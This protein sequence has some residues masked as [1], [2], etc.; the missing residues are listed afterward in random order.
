MSAGSAIEKLLDKIDSDLSDFLVFAGILDNNAKLLSYRV[1]KSSFSL[2]IERHDTLDVQIAL[3]FSL[4]KQLE[5]ISGAHKLTVTRFANHD[6]FMFGNQD[7]HIFVITSPTAD[8]RVAKSLVDLVGTI[9]H[10]AANLENAITKATAGVSS[11][12]EQAVPAAISSQRHS[13]RSE[14]AHVDRNGLVFQ[15]PRPEAVAMLQGY[16]M[17]LE[18]GCIIE[19]DIEGRYKLKAVEGDGHLSWS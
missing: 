13:V 18:P 15:R 14:Q 19:D 11:K 4:I 7:L 12:K 6:I 5:D 2:P 17:G 10:G 3:M 9:S 1:G 16:L 8:E